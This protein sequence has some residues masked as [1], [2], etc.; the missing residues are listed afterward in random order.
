MVMTDDWWLIDISL[1]DDWW[2]IDGLLIDIDGCVIDGWFTNSF[3]MNQ[4]Q[5]MNDDGEVNP[6]MLQRQGSRYSGYYAPVN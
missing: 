5:A 4:C 3:T 6:L 2:T 1:M